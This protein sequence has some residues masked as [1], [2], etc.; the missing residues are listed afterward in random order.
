MKNSLTFQEARELLLAETRPMGAETVYLA[1][2]AGRVLAQNIL[3]G[4]DVPPFDASPYDGYAFRA[5][6]SAGATGETPVTLRVLEEIPA[7]STAKYPIIPG[8]AARIMTGAPIPDGADAVVMYEK[9]EFTRE[10]VKLFAPAKCGENIIRAG[11]DVKAGTVLAEPGDVIDAGTLG[12]VA[13]QG[14]EELSVHRI[15]RVG[16]IST[17][18]ELTE[19]GQTGGPGKIF[20]SNRYTFTALLRGAGCAPVYMGTAGDE[21]G[22]ITA[23]IRKGLAECDAVLLT[24]G[25]SVGDYDLTPDA[26]VAAGGRILFREVGIKPGMACCYG[27]KDEKLIL[28]LSGNPASAVTSFHAVAA[29]ALRKLCGRKDCLPREVTLTLAGGFS[30]KSP[31]T[32]L[33]R[34]RMD[35]SDGTARFV[36]PKDQGN[37]VLSSTIGCDVIAVVPAGSGPI[38]PGSRLKGFLL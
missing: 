28:G 8:T 33:L 19:P 25:V 1:E 16:I 29:P 36:M 2:A 35:V 5:E 24:G 26:V 20:N 37:V 13:S 14:L 18:S 22:A 38:A 9:T 27:V 21:A 30:K 3:A 11:E 31:V 32:R 10:T 6:D 17:G 4:G 34:G 12:T 7:G 15:P 23:L